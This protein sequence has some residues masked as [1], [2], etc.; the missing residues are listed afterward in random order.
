METPIKM[1][2]ITEDQAS[3]LDIKDGQ[4]IFTTD[5]NKIYL[6]MDGNRECYTRENIKT[7]VQTDEPQD[8]R[9]GD[10]WLVTEGE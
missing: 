2:K 7:F 8:A 10:V 4:L 5:T 6:D 3:S 9:D 1:Y